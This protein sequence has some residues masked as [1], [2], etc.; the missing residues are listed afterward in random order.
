MCNAISKHNTQ[1]GT[2]T[3]MLITVSFV[4][5]PAQLE[6]FDWAKRILTLN[7]QFAWTMKSVAR[8]LLY[9]KTTNQITKGN[10]VY[11]YTK[12]SQN[13][14]KYTT[15]FLKHMP[16][17]VF[18]IQRKKC[19]GCYLSR[20]KS[21]WIKLCEKCSQQKNQGDRLICPWPEHFT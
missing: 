3:R 14:A 5:S 2:D 4:K 11:N 16:Q 8:F 9:L 15:L 18:K 20:K 13:S 19:H 1:I 12:T 6:S 21:P 17:F 7:H 10:D